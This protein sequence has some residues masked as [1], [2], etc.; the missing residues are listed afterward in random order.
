MCELVSGAAERFGGFREH[1]VVWRR[2]L[3]EVKRSKVT[4]GWGAC[5]LLGLV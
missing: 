4:G 2:R 3:S 1:F 5:V